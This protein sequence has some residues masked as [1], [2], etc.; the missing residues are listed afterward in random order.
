MSLKEKIYDELMIATDIISGRYLSEKYL[1]SRSA[2]WNIVQELK[3][4]N[5]PIISSRRGYKIDERYDIVSKKCIEYYIKN[6]VE[7]IVKESVDSTMDEAEYDYKINKKFDRLIISREQRKG[8]G[9]R[10]RK[11][12]SPRDKGIYMTL[13]L[14][15]IYNYEESLKVTNIAAVA[16]ADAIKN[17]INID[18]KIKWINDIFIGDK[19]IG[20]ILTKASTNLENENLEVIYLGIGINIEYSKNLDYIVENKVGALF[21]GFSKKNFKSKLCANIIDYFY[22]MYENINNVE[23]I[24]KYSNYLYMKNDRCSLLID[25]SL[26]EDVEILGVDENYRLIIKDKT[27]I[28]SIYQGEVTIRK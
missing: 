9:R 24:E 13:T 18:V 16:V 15:P 6:K 3:K 25:N 7:V 22:K 27:G 8:C 28:N 12:I 19:K 26:R 11:F 4:E 14:K 20:G 23:Y 2:I 17:L 10:G 21:N 5:I 1:V